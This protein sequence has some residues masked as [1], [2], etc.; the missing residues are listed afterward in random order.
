MSFSQSCGVSL[1]QPQL[2]TLEGPLLV[3]EK[4][5]IFPDVEAGMELEEGLGQHVGLSCEFRLGGEFKLA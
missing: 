2:L 1:W 4:N 5:S 3:Q